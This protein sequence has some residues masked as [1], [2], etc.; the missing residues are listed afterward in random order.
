VGGLD[1]ERAARVQHMEDEAANN[2]RNFEYMQEIRRAGW[3][4]VCG[5]LVGRWLLG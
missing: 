3:K 5:Q 2:R 4:K 1:A